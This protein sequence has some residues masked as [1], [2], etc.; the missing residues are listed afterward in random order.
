MAGNPY[1]RLDPDRIV[2]TSEQLSRRVAERFPESGLSRIAQELHAI[3]SRAKVSSARIQRPN[4]LLRA[5]VLAL[6]GAVLAVAIQV[7]LQ[8]RLKTEVEG[9]SEFAQF[10]EATLG[11]FVFLGAGIA[12]LVTLES[13]LRRNKALRAVYELRSIAH[14]ID[15]HQL[16]KDPDHVLHGGPSTQSSPRRRMT[17]FQLG[18]YLDYCT[19]LLSLVSKIAVLYIQGF[20]DPIALDAVDQ[21]ENLTTGLSRKIWQK[22]MLLGRIP[23]PEL[24]P[25]SASLG[26]GSGAPGAAGDRQ[27]GGQGT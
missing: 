17:P 21:I 9:V 15:M 26:T 22:L 12:F 27:T 20:S 1:N 14:I 25:D 6:L 5:L 2:A 4:Y 3:A 24:S 23:S 16:T 8:L 7:S 13:R 18:R 19:E 11:S 10:I